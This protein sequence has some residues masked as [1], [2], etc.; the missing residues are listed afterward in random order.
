MTIRDVVFRDIKTTTVTQMRDVHFRDKIIKDCILL[1]PLLTVGMFSS[2]IVSCLHLFLGSP[3]FRFRG[4]LLSQVCIRFR[5]LPL[6]CKN[7][8]KNLDFFCFVTSLLTF[9]SGSA[10]RFISQRYRG[11]GSASG[12]V[13]KCH[14][15]TWLIETRSH[16]VQ[17]KY[18]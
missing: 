12:P 2:R 18:Y 15:S 6:S 1:G 8:N 17:V 16:N 9:S 10:R 5:I 7:S 11:S 3:R 4:I 13:P 14:G